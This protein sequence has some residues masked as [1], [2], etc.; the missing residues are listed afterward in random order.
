V[1]KVGP[2]IGACFGDRRGGRVALVAQ[3]RG[4][5]RYGCQRQSAW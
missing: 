5:C 3:A 1:V 4:G 2:Y